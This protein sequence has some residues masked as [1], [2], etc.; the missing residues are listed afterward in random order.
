MGWN[1]ISQFYLKGKS[2]KAVKEFFKEEFEREDNFELIDY[3]RKGN[4]VYMAVK[5][6]VKNEVFAVVTMISFQDGEFF[7]KE[8]DETVGPVQVECPQRIL[9]KLSPT[10]HEYAK[11]WRKRCWE[12]HERNST[13]KYEHG[14]VLQFPNKISF[15]N[16]FEGD[17]F[18]LL[19]EGRR[20]RFVPY[21]NQSDISGVCGRYQISRWRKREPKII[22]TLAS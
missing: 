16:G 2:S 4:T 12:Y 17:T 22:K 6:I 7:W 14:Q 15:T 11:D 10:E 5:N 8:M 9:K 21:V 3:S 1:G 18:V 19:K 13:K 20:F